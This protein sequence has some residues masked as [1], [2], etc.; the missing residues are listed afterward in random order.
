ML[1]DESMESRHIWKAVVRDP[2]GNNFKPEDSGLK[3]SRPTLG[4]LEKY[5]TVWVLLSMA[6]GFL[7]GKLVPELG[8]WIEQL[9]VSDISV[10]MGVA[11]FLI[12]YP[13]M[14]SIEFKEL[15]KAAKSPK[16]AILT[17]VG[18][19]MVAPALMTLLARLFLNSYP[20]FAAGVILLGIA[21]CTGMVLFWILL[22]GGDV[23]KGVV[24]TA[25]N[26]LSTLILYTPLAALY[27]GVGG[28]PIPIDPIAKSVILFVGLPL[29]LGQ[30]TRRILLKKKGE[31][32]FRE[33]F[34]PIM[35]NTAVIALLVTVIILFS[36]KGEIIAE[37]PFLVGLISAPLLAHFFIMASLFYIIPWL[38][39]FQY[40]DAVTVAFISSGTQFEVAIATAI[41]VFGVGSGAALATVVGPLWEVPSMLLFVKIAAKTKHRFSGSKGS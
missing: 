6:M 36:L 10:P 35:G 11:L 33:R 25:I 32:W 16:P 24:I 8:I 1:I 37:E 30:T 39:G 26:A 40:G 19:W 34:Q 27:L 23:A 29:A 18:N 12:M 20:Q 9:Q 31:A 14:A 28:I 2:G 5:M 3:Q 13:T 41:T 17:L 38:L 15:V 21:P 4:K 7:L 22:A